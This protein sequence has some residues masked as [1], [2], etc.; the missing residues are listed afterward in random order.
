MA[1]GFD[2]LTTADRALIGRVDTS[3]TVVEERRNKA[4]P[5]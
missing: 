4:A 3:V 2:D 5:P 1:C